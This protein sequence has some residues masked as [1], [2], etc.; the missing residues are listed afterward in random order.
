[1][2]FLEHFLGQEQFLLFCEVV[3]F[4]Q[5]S[6]RYEYART[7]KALGIMPKKTSG[8]VCLVTE[9]SVTAKLFCVSGPK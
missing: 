3:K 5:L 9:L 1:M 2:T 6:S 8:G 7:R 4:F